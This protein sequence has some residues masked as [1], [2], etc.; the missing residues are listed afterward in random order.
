MQASELSRMIEE[1][2]DRS[3]PG[4]VNYILGKLADADRFIEAQKNSKDMISFS[5]QRVIHTITEGYDI[6]GRDDL[7]AGKK[8]EYLYRGMLEGA[9]FNRKVLRKMIHILSE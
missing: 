5:I 9:L 3:D 2:R 1:G 8:S 4:K 7:N 6:D